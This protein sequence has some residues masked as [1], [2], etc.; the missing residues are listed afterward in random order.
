MFIPAKYPEGRGGGAVDGN[1]VPAAVDERHL[2]AD[3]KVGD[4]AKSLRIRKE[5]EKVES[6]KASCWIEE[7]KNTSVI[8]NNTITS[9]LNTV[10]NSTSF[11]PTRSTR[12]RRGNLRQ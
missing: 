4:A 5:G 7:K 10:E 11:P 9:N 3:F 12:A 1:R 2:S 8:F 6:V